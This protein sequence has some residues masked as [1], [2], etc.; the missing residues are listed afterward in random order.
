MVYIATTRTTV[1]LRVVVTDAAMHVSSTTVPQAQIVLETLY[2]AASKAQLVSATT[3]GT[4][5][6]NPT[7]HIVIPSSFRTRTGR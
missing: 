4:G 5:G 1:E 6:E 2:A 3:E 7:N